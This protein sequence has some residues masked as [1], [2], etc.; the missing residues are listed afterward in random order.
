MSVA[1]LF[2]SSPMPKL[3]A[4]SSARRGGAD[5]LAEMV[6]GILVDPSAFFDALSP[7]RRV[8]SA[9]SQ[10]S[11]HATPSVRAKTPLRSARGLPSATRPAQPQ[12]GPDPSDSHVRHSIEPRRSIAVLLLGAAVMIGA[13]VIGA[14]VASADPRSSQPTL[15][16]PVAVLV[17]PGDS[18]WSIARRM[19]PT[20]DVRPLVDSMVSS[21]GSASIVAGETLL[22]TVP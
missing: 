8:Q 14:E 7:A 20:G 10:S 1:S 3:S 19:Q 13:V 12:N 16:R 15:N 18:L 11:L 9:A 17:Q 22:V 5:A 6:G 21:H 2:S 4:V